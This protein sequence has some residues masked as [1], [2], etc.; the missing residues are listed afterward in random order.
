VTTCVETD[1][2]GRVIPPTELPTSYNARRSGDITNRWN[3]IVNQVTEVIDALREDDPRAADQLLPLV[4]QELRRLAAARLRREPSGQTL[5]PTALVHEAYL[6]LLDGNVPKDWDGRG[7]FF[8]AAA[9]AMRRILI[10]RAR[11]KQSLKRG[12]QRG[13]REPLSSIAAPQSADSI[14]ILEVS[15]ALDQLAKTD[16]QAAEL[17]KLRY[18]AGLTTKEA[19]ACLEISPRS[20]DR[21]WAYARSWLKMNIQGKNSQ[22]D[23]KA[24]E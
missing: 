12:G 23:G 1:A 2:P 18:F 22:K 3:R 11:Q 14:E 8:A 19:A 7:H 16:A 9:E 17:V 10:D 5:Q 4:Y 21:V 6:K 20:A 13:D 15:D 24:T